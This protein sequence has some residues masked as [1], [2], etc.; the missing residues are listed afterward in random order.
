M[1][2]DTPFSFDSYQDALKAHGF[3][4]LDAH[5]LSHH[6]KNSYLRLA[7]RTLKIGGDQAEHYAQL[8]TAYRETARAVD[9]QEVGWG[10]FVCQK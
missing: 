6:L 1:L 10:L 4:M 8:T 9:K 2:F 3:K 5:D 7:D